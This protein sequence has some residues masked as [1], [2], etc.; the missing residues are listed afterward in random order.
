MK[1]VGENPKSE[2]IIKPGNPKQIH[3][4]SIQEIAKNYEIVL[5][6]NQKKIF[7]CKEYIFIR[8]QNILEMVFFALFLK[9]ITELIYG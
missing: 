8:A 1:E 5:A 6:Q 7:E 3:T 2:A 9:I 4:E